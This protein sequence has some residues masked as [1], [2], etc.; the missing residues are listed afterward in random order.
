MEAHSMMQMMEPH[1]IPSVE[2]ANEILESAGAAEPHLNVEKLD[3]TIVGMFY[4]AT[5]EA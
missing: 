1:A 5:K 4:T 3:T 2:N